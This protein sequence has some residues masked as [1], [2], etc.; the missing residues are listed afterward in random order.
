MYV[1]T[2]SPLE[3][4]ITGLQIIPD[5]DRQNVNDLSWVL[6]EHTPLFV[7]Y[8]AVLGIQHRGPR[9]SS[10]IRIRSA[11][12]GSGQHDTPDVIVYLECRTR[13]IMVI[14]LATQTADGLLALER[15]RVYLCFGAPQP[16]LEYPLFTGAVIRP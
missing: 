13:M 9:K 11:N 14:T 12:Q 1:S 16:V 15:K 2:M 10:R 7:T 4:S 8:S 3:H 6:G 5:G